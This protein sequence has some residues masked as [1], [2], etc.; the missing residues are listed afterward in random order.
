MSE[1][2]RAVRE[3]AGY[4]MVEVLV[5]I[6]ITT[7]GFLSLINLQIGTLHAVG[8]SRSMMQAVNL[9]EHFIETLKAEAIPW[10]MDASVMVADAGRFPHLRLV[11][12]PNTGGS[13]GW[14]RGYMSPDQDKRVGQLGNDTWYD[15]G[16]AAEV[17]NARDRRFCVHYRLTWIVP[18]YLIRSDV[19]VLWLRDEARLS[20]YQECPIGMETDLANITSITVPGTI[21]RNVFTK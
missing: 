12:N 3:D 13:S 6:V 1:R 2:K 5:V 14:I 16:I 18:N 10:N 19:R 8:T 4:S 21:I 17:P 7:V 20:V 9:A 15:T 11:G